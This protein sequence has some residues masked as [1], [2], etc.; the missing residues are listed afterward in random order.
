[1][2]LRTFSGQEVC[3]E[4]RVI[5]ATLKRFA[6][7]GHDLLPRPAGVIQRNGPSEDC[8][9]RRQHGSPRFVRIPDKVR[10]RVRQ[11][12]CHICI[13]GGADAEVC[14]VFIFMSARFIDVRK[15]G[16]A[17]RKE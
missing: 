14:Y 5:A 15:D 2:L 6:H 9:D 10:F 8:F 12:E 3:R 1:M 4:K 16:R 17:G 7:R 13:V 11:L